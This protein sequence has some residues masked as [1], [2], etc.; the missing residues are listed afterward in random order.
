[1]PVATAMNPDLLP[2]IVPFILFMSFIGVEEAGRFLVKKDMVT[3]SEQFFLYLYPVKTASVAVVLF[4]FRKSYSEILLSQLRNLRHTTVSIVCGVAVFAAW[5]QMDSFTTPLAVTQGFNPYLIHDLPVQ[6]FMTSMRLAGA[7]LIVPLMEEL[8]WRSFLVR[9]LI[10]T[11]FSKVTIGQFTWTSFLV[12]AILFGLEHNM[13][14][15]GVMAGAAYNLLL[16]YTRSIAHC[17]LAHALT[18]LLLG[19]YVLATCQWHFW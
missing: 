19:L 7:V 13:F 2:R 10:N 5:I 11:N 4:Y 14:L 9:Y 1:M 17:I 15:A 8:F 18:N 16:N 3:L 12:S 6:I